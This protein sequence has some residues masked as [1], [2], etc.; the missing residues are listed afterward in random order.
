MEWIPSFEPVWLG[1]WLPLTLAFTIQWMLLFSMP[2][3]VFARLFDRKGWSKKQ[4]VYFRLGKLASVI[5]LVFL[6]FAP[7]KTGSAIFLTGSCV[8]LTGLVGIVIFLFNYRDTPLDQPVTKG[9]Y[10]I[11]RH[12]QIVSTTLVV[13]GVCMAVGSG[14]AVLFLLIAK[15]LEH[16]G[17]LA[18]EKACLEQ[19]GAPYK[20]FLEKVPRY[21]LFF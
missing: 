16:H 17:I 9:L 10:R 19:Y 15:I 1:G 6:C 4:R 20:A 11:S 2:K 5:C 14:M 7:L 8:S 12:P 13:L 3:E 21:F 18:E